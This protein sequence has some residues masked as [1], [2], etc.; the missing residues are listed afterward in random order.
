MCISNGSNG[1]PKCCT[2]LPTRWAKT[3][4]Q[5]A[6]LGMFNANSDKC[7]CHSNAVRM[8]NT[9][10]CLCKW[11]VSMQCSEQTR[12]KCVTIMLENC[13]RMLCACTGDIR[14]SSVSLYRCIGILRKTAAVFN[15]KS[16]STMFTACAH[17]F[18]L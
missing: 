3:T 14:A 15:L 1:N 9:V 2:Q 11:Y 13:D 16:I 12:V 7:A 17:L 8:Q 18:A 5:R 4:A 10:Q 6:Q